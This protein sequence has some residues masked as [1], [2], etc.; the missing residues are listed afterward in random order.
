MK[1]AKIFL[2][3]VAAGVSI[4]LGGTIFLSMDNKVLGALFFTVGL[5][6]ICTN[7]YHLFT[8]KV[9]YFFDKGSCSLLDLLII[10]VGNLAGTWLTAEAVRAT[11]IASLSEKAAAICQIK[12]DDSVFSI[13]LLAGFCTILIFFAVDG[14]N[15]NSHEIGKYLSLFF[16]VM[17]FILSG[18]EHCVAN[19][20]YFSVAAMWSGKT[21]L[22]VLVMTLGNS[23]GGMIFPLLRKF[24]TKGV[25][26]GVS[27]GR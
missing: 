17:V 20:Y 13:F 3:S 21:L 15:R 2:S 8:G 6:V 24:I 14:F 27:A 25:L 19:M 9:C 5:F 10:W 4:A 23:V 1:Q 26:T 16:G 12:L 18:F 7:G 11:R 22:Y